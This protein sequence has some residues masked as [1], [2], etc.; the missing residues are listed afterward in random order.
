MKRNLFT[1]FF[2][3]C[4][5]IILVSL[6]LFG[7][8]LVALSANYFRLE[9]MKTLERLTSQASAIVA[10]NFEANFY[11]YVD[12]RMLT[13]YFSILSPTSEPDIFLTNLEG[14]IVLCTDPM[15]KDRL[16]PQAVTDQ[17]FGGG[18]RRVGRMEGMYEKVSYMVGVPVVSNG[19]VIGAVFA[20]SDTSSVFLL[21]KEVMRL[22]LLGASLVALISFAIIYFAT[23]A[24]VRPLGA[25]LQATRSFARGDFSARVPVEGDAEIEQLAMAFNNMA[26]S[27]A[28]QE[29][30]DRTFI[31]NVSHELR[32][33]MTTIGGFIDGIL[34]GTIE[35]SQYEHYLRIVSTEV[36]R[37]SRL[38]VSMLNM[39]RIAAGEMPLHPIPVELHEII[40]RTV[41]GFEHTIEEKHIEIIGLDTEEKNYVQADPDLV[42]QILY[43]LIENAVKF[44]PVNGGIEI[45]CAPDGKMILTSIKNT[46]QGISKEEIPRLFDRFYKGDRSRAMDTNGVGIGLHIVKSLV[47]LHGGDITV[48]SVEGEYAEFLFTLPAAPQK[49]GSALFRKT[50][51]S[52]L[53][54]PTESAN[55]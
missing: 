29:G 32:T 48:K 20:V 2:T 50:E 46:G 49:S 44:T 7:V 8:V 36:K 37:L 51:K 31:A 15:L 43:N 17:A 21:L 12:A 11:R 3:L 38:V 6:T 40:C 35:P 18:Y 39:S 47:H 30:T 27:L 4:A 54:E 10:E 5:S 33:P 9:N 55:E 42:H 25:M 22:F 14:R 19:S 28:T 16:L 52:R 23:Q 45:S 41:L 26:Q 34:D 24:L 1:R 53:P 13:T